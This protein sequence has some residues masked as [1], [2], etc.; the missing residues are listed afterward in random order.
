MTEDDT[1]GFHRTADEAARLGHPSYVWHA[2]RSGGWRKCDTG[3]T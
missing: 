1:D 2:G 3:P